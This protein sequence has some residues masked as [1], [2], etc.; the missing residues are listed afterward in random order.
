MMSHLWA[1]DNGELLMSKVKY[2]HAFQTDLLHLLNVIMLHHD[3]KHEIG[4]KVKFP[5][6]FG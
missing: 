5:A 1:E 3:A 2:L 6:M 4:F